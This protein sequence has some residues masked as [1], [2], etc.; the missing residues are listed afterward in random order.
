MQKENNFILTKANEV[1]LNSKPDLESNKVKEAEDDK[2]TLKEIKDTIQNIKRRE[3][4]R[5]KEANLVNYIKLETI[6]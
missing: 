6:K 4:A 2:T 1:L 3:V 5:H